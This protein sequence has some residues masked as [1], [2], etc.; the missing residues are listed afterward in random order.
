MVAKPRRRDDQEPPGSGVPVT[1]IDSGLDLEHP[2]FAARP[3]TTMPF[4]CA[5]SRQTSALVLLERERGS[6]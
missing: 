4:A 3:D 6:R 5:C 2:E 1:V